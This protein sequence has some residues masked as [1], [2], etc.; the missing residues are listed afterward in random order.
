MG[1]LAGKCVLV[2]DD[3]FVLAINLVEFLEQEGCR[4]VRRVASVEGAVTCILE[5][6]PDLAILDIDLGDETSKEIADELVAAGVPFVFLS[7]HERDA[8]PEEHVSRE[9]MRKPWTPEAMRER[10][11]MLLG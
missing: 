4:V 2:V 6:R 1:S 8:V 11:G 5:D 9:F 10:L 3:D 7:A